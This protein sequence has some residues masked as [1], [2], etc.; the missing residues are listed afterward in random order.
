MIEMPPG[1]P[2]PSSR[3]A[4]VG[5][6]QVGST[7]ANDLILGSVATE[8]LLVDVKVELRDAQVRDLSDVTYSRNSA[9]SV[10][11]G[12][13]HEAGQCDIVV[14]TAGSKCCS[15]KGSDERKLINLLSCML[16]LIWL[17]RPTQYRPYISE[18]CN[19]SEGNSSDE[20][21]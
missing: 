5:V 10:R 3:I 4:I 9:T 11:G 2:Q 15:G 17:L 8:L 16:E 20:T 6:G 7:A 12:T 1:N 13:H 19:S 21:I 14:I 18:H